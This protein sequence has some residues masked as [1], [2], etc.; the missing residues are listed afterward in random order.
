M[1]T[2]PEHEREIENRNRL[3]L[4][5]GLPLLDPD[6]ELARMAEVERDQAF[7]RYVADNRLEYQRLWDECSQRYGAGVSLNVFSKM[8]VEA[9]VLTIMRARW[10]SIGAFVRRLGCAEHK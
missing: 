5:M 7:R 4:E 6:V 3:R 8:A 2:R 1:G 10:S 9:R